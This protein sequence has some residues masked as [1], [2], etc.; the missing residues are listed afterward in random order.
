M[1]FAKTVLRPLSQL[2]LQFPDVNPVIML[3]DLFREFQAANSVLAC[4]G[5]REQFPMENALALTQL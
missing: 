5:H 3:K 1:G 4:K 2:L